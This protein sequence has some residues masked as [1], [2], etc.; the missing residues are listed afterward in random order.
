MPVKIVG[1]AVGTDD[2][3]DHAR[4]DRAVVDLQVGVRLCVI[5]LTPGGNGQNRECAC[6]GEAG[7]VLIGSW[8][9]DVLA[10][11][12]KSP[13]ISRITNHPRLPTYL[14][15]VAPSLRADSPNR[16]RHACRAENR[17]LDVAG[18]VDH[19]G[20]AGHA[21]EHRTIPAAR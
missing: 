1:V 16:F 5:D 9:G 6:H 11:L 19:R 20:R 2:V 8:T 18:A 15:I 10:A 7:P 17:A 14:A 13:T 21:V 12:V 4:H 3:A